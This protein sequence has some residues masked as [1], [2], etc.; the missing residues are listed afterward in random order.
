MCQEKT[1]KVEKS[2]K[3]IYK[4]PVDMVDIDIDTSA[5]VAVSA[6]P[7]A[8]PSGAGTGSPSMWL[9]WHPFKTLGKSDQI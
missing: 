1:T 3:I 4:S 5:S 9:S 6:L 7:L 2:D 8:S